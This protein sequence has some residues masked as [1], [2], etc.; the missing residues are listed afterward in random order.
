MLQHVLEHGPQPNTPALL[1]YPHIYKYISV[2]CILE[3]KKYN[4]GCIV[5][6][7]SKR[8]DLLE[9]KMGVIW[10]LSLEFFYYRLLV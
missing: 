1:T 8:Q 2:S 3:K 10:D 5:C 9:R 7:L 4:V 6:D